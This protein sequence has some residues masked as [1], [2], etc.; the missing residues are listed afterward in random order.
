MINNLIAHLEKNFQNYENLLKSKQKNHCCLT[1]AEFKNSPKSFT[2]SIFLIEK[3]RAIQRKSFYLNYGLKERLIDLLLA[4]NAKLRFPKLRLLL[5]LLALNAQICIMFFLIAFSRRRVIVEG[6]I[7]DEIYGIVMYPSFTSY[8]KNIHRPLSPL[9]NEL[10]AE[11]NNLK[12]FRVSLDIIKKFQLI[13]FLILLPTFFLELSLFIRANY[14]ND[15]IGLQ[16]LGTMCIINRFFA[17]IL[18]KNGYSVYLK[19]HGIVRDCVAEYGIFTEASGYKDGSKPI[20][21]D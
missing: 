4:F 10:K 5:D 17:I 18:K 3:Y 8:I 15:F 12:H 1:Y 21:E 11:Q 20:S 16:C 14:R 19:N 2:D 13:G 9:S 6:G 7:Q